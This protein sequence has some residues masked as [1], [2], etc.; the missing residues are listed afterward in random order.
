VLKGKLGR[1]DKK[2]KKK[3]KNFFLFLEFIFRKRIIHKSHEKIF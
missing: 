3:G 1:K 2:K